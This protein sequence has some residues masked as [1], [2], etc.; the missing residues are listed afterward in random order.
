MGIVTASLWTRKGW[1]ERQRGRAAATRRTWSPPG[2]PRKRGATRCRAERR[3]EVGRLHGDEGGWVIGGRMRGV[4]GNTMYGRARRNIAEQR[5]AGPCSNTSQND[6]WRGRL[7]PDHDKVVSV[8]PD[9]PS[10]RTARRQSFHRFVRQ[11]SP[12]WS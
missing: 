6:V 11:S 3:R 10:A 7:V 2:N 12:T 1:R 9:A 4:R 8:H 5:G